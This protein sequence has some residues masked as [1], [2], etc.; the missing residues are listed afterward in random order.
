LSATTSGS[1]SSPGS[2]SRSRPTKLWASQESCSSSDASFAALA[3]GYL[4]WGHGTE[5]LPAL[6]VDRDTGALLRG[7]AM[8]RPRA[9][10]TLR[11]TVKPIPTRTVTAILP[12]QSEEA[13]IFNTHTDGQGFVEENG[14]VAFVHLARHFASLPR[15]LRPRR[16]LVFAAWPGHMTYDLPQAQGWIDAYPSWSSAPPPC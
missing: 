5:P 6:Y 10:L 13:I 16:T 1:G 2:G 8:T 14:G 4:P 7:Q 15:R 9:R 11:A 12:G 3:G